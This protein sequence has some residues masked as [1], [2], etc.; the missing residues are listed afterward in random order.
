MRSRPALTV[1]LGLVGLP[2][3]VMA[4]AVEVQVELPRASRIDLAEEGYTTLAVTP[5]LAS[6]DSDRRDYAFE[7]ETSRFFERLFAKET[8]LELVQ[9][10]SQPLPFSTVDA[11]ADDAGYWQKL[12]DDL[13]ADLVLTGQVAFQTTNRSGYVQNEYRSPTTGRTY[14]DRPTFVYRSGVTLRIEVLLIEG[15]TGE[16]LY[17]DRFMKDRTVDGS[18]GDSLQNFFDLLRGVS[19][20]V[21]GIVKPQKTVATRY[22]LD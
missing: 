1:F 12:S 6:E 7:R 20:S 14:M 3:L 19:T 8:E 11:L 17:R 2:G 10:P 16:V 9:S 4:G 15:E 18:G 22:L 21:L 13:G 5:F